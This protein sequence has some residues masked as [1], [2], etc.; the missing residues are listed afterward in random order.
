M[1]PGQPPKIAILLLA[2]G[3][4]SR[5]RGGDKL[6]EEV[7]GSALLTTMV[8]RS[9]AT[10]L[11]VFV[12]LPAPDHPRAA[13][14]DGAITAVVPDAAEGMSASIRRGVAALPPSLDAVIILPADM[15]EITTEDIEML[16]R[17][18]D[19]RS[20]SVMRG[21]GS[22]GQPGHP[23]LFPQACFGDLQ[24]LCG[25]Q[26]ARNLIKSGK[27][28]LRLVPLPENHALTDLDTP[29]AWARWRAHQK[30]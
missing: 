29:E 27:Y 2:A 7:D 17:A 14:T 15:P 6:T 20:P 3:Q 30:L 22:D 24:K 5:M 26:G 13:L 19:Q 10:G 25:D 28:P 8:R 21:A 4:S 18:F 1:E 9:R 11:P 16:A 23:V 12:T